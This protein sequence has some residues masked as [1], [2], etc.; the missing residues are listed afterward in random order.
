MHKISFLP[1]DQPPPP[2][3]DVP[4]YSIHIDQGAHMTSHSAGHMLLL[5]KGLGLS[6]CFTPILFFIFSQKE[7]Y[8]APFGDRPSCET[9][10]LFH[11][12]VGII[13]MPNDFI[14]LVESSRQQHVPSSSILGHLRD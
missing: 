13:V 12:N 1:T 10:Q 5:T 7:N 14:P 11:I 9:S 2:A 4:T 6:S 3:F 8:Q